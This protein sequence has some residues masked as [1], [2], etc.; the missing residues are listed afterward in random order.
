MSLKT[1]R[2]P[3]A[4]VDCCALGN[5]HVLDWG[6]AGLLETLATLERL[7]IRTAGAGRDLAQARAPAILEIA[8]KG[9]LLVFSR[10]RRAASHGIGERL[11]WPLA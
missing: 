10:P 8:G 5:N 7:G 9:R 11:R 6:R 3:A 4:G 2:L 1:P